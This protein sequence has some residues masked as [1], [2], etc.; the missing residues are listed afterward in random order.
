MVT[1]LTHLISRFALSKHFFW[2][3]TLLATA[4]GGLLRFGNLA[5]PKAL[6]FDETY[7]VK[8]A[9]TLGQTGAER[10]W[11]EG[12]NPSFEAGDYSGFLAEGAYVVHPPIGKWVIYL[13]MQLFGAD[14]S[15]GWRFSVALLGTLAIPLLILIARLLLKSNRFAVLAGAFLAI[16]GQSIVMSRTAVLDGVLT[17]FVLLGFLF[18][19]LDQQSWAKRFAAGVVIGF[20]PYLMLTSIALGLAAGTKWSGLYF[21]AIFGFFTVLS[22]S[23]HRS[24]LGTNPWLSIPQGAI[25]ALIMLPTAV[26]VYVLGWLGWILGNDGWGRTFAPTWWGSLW[27]YHLNAYRFHT[28]LNKDHPY[29]SNAL[30]WLLSLRPTAFYFDQ[31]ETCGAL[32]DCTVAITAIPNPAIWIAGLLAMIWALY[33]FVAKFDLTAGVISLGFLAGWAPWLVYLSRTTFQFYSVVFVPFLILALCFALQRY[34]RRGIVL[35]RV[36]E[37]ERS[38]VSLLVLA[39]LLGL[40]FASIWMG[41]PVPHWVW[42][43]QMWF[44]FWV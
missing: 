19:V 6:V 12:Y 44:P 17:F 41:L 31:P 22:D 7:Y 8:D 24:K 23:M 40:Y 3:G 33:R 29:S 43:I 35:R 20:R 30:E 13:G 11:P 9:W 18:F 10:V 32:S 37:R 21:L 2:V 14:S 16:E 28:G 34:L 5:N 38:I 42:Q 4:L 36:S 25:N 27:E 15:F 1:A 39:M 26:M